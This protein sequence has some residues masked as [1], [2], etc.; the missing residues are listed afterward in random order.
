MI[1]GNNNNNDNIST[2]NNNVMLKTTHRPMNNNPFIKF[3]IAMLPCHFGTNLFSF[4]F[5]PPLLSIIEHFYCIKFC[6]AYSLLNI[7]C[8]S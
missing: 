7:H 6:P 2:N 5:A 3:R 8:W 4:N 1:A